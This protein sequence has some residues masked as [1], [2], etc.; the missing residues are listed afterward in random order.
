MTIMEVFPFANLPNTELIHLLSQ[1]AASDLDINGLL[2]MNVINPENDDADQA[3]FPQALLDLNLNSNNC[4]Y[5]SLDDTGSWPQLINPLMIV[6]INCRSLN[7][8]SNAIFDFLHSLTPQPAIIALSE[9]WLKPSSPLDIFQIDNYSLVSKPRT[10]KRSGGGVAIYVHNSI[11]YNVID[12]PET[13]TDETFEFLA[14]DLNY[15]SNSNLKIIEIYRPPDTSINMFNTAL[16]NLLDTLTRGKSQLMLA[17]DFNL[18]LNMLNAANSTSIDFKNLLCSHGFIPTITVPTRISSSTSTLID[19]IFI[20]KLPTNYYSRVIF[21]DFSDHLPILLTFESSPN[22]HLH[23]VKI[24]VE[25]KR[26]FSHTNIKQFKNLISSANWFENIENNNYQNPSTIETNYMHFLTKFKR[27]F[28]QAFPLTLPQNNSR[29]SQHRLNSP[30]ITPALK[31]ACSRKRKLLKIKNKYPTQNNIIAYTTFRNNL[32]RLLRKQERSYFLS[33]FQKLSNNPIQTWSLINSIIK[34]NKKTSR[35]SRQ[36][37]KLNYNGDTK[38][39]PQDIANAFNHFFTNIGVFKEDK[40]NCNP[41]TFNDFLHTTNPNSC[42]LY[43]TDNNEIISITNS[44]EKKTTCGDDEISLLVI[45]IVIESIAPILATLINQTMAQGYFPNSLK[46]AKVIP[47]YKSGPKDNISNYRPISILNSFSKIYEKIIQIRLDSFI[48]KNNLLDNSQYGFRK[49]HSTEFALINLVDKIANFIE[50]KKYVICIMIDI[51][52]AFDSLNHKILIGKLLNYGFRGNVIKLLQS[53]LSNRYQYVVYNGQTSTSRQITTGIPQGSILGPLLFLLYINDLKTSLNE[54]TPILFADDATLTYANYSLPTLINTVNSELASMSSWMIANK[55]SINVNKTNYML[56]QN[57]SINP[58]NLLIKLD[59]ITLNEV[60]STKILGVIIDNKLNW[61]FHI[62]ELNT[63]ISSVLFILHKIRYQIN[64][65]IALLIYKS[66]V[67]SH[68]QY[69]ILL[70]GKTC[71]TFLK[72][73]QILQNKCIK[74]CLSLPSKTSSIVIFKKAN[75]LTIEQLYIY[76]IA[77]LIYKFINEPTSI[78]ANIVNIFKLTS[79][80][81]A[82]PTRQSKNTDLFNFPHSSAAKSQSIK[83][84]APQAWNSIPLELKSLKSI[85]TFKSRLKSHLINN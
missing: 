13:I 68:L 10:T 80:I 74:C 19:N 46:V 7:K 78:P 49:Q 57:H 55:L 8:N 16:S 22:Q 27:I 23:S 3:L 85:H 39:E 83:I 5:S 66:L 9:T 42:Y 60:T 25:P 84:Q 12:I 37:E 34:N 24:T 44:M 18:D 33:E 30:W 79:S 54:D 72:Q 15:N 52:K 64:F 58:T 2:D 45:K 14:L 67:F 47:I 6:Q 48:T 4:S 31:A 75:T 28:Q 65:S 1:S 50:D 63:K 35:H 11:S 53:Y 20:N 32:K 51:K 43:P 62:N 82:Y 76:K 61:K 69:G 17:G 56:F 41:K 26:I 29:S 73:T 71:P 40:I 59:N 77:T 36:A 21:E 38:T 70:C 81:H